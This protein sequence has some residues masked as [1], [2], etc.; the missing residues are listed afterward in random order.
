M[1]EETWLP[2]QQGKQSCRANKR[3]K[4]KASRKTKMARPE[5]Q[6]LISIKSRQEVIHRYPL[7]RSMERRIPA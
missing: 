2:L 7:R 1:V 5:L 6:L 3:L 4:R